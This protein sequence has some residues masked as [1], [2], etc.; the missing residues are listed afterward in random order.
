MIQRIFYFYDLSLGL[1]DVIIELLKK[2]YYNITIEC[3]DIS[4]FTYEIKHTILNN[5]ITLDIVSDNEK[6]NDAYQIAYQ[7]SV[8]NRT[9]R[10]GNENITPSEKKNKTTLL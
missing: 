5:W 10:F 9:I 6:A 3:E 7:N 2:K 8:Q 4:N 1:Q